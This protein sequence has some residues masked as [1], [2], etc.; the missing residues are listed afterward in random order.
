LIIVVGIGAGIIVDHFFPCEDY[1]TPLFIVLA[2]YI[3]LEDMF[4]KERKKKK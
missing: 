2:I 3:Y 4:E 1:M